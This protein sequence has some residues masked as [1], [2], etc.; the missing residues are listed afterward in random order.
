MDIEKNAVAGS[1][2]SSDVFVEV[3]PKTNG[4]E[5]EVQSVVYQQFGK[6]IEKTV[7]DVLNEFE[8]KSAAV[9][10]TDHGALDCTIRARVETAL[11]RAEGG[12]VK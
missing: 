4:I 1:F 10:L 6:A 3:A 7:R 9:K 2:E 12:T 5:I 8:V 11:K